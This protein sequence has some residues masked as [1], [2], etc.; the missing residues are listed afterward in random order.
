MINRLA[1]LLIPALLV[2]AGSYTPTT[3]GQGA[4]I[5][6][7]GDIIGTVDGIS[8]APNSESPSAPPMHLTVT[9]PSF[10][11]TVDRALRGQ[12]NF[13]NSCSRRLYWL[14]KT[15][16]LQYGS[17]LSLSSVARYEQRLCSSFNSFFSRI[18][19]PVTATKAVHWR[20]FVK[21]SPLANLHV[22]IEI[23]TVADIQSD[24]ETAF[25]LRASEDI[26]LPLPTSCGPCEC[27]DII[28]TLSP[29]VTTNHFSDGGNAAVLLTIAFSTAR[30]ARVLACLR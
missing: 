14:G 7:H 17:S 30:D 3:A 23:T 20:L 27:S 4:A 24:L 26:P 16:I 8:L 21:P 18:I 6:L 11:Q 22:S 13:I 9:F 29:E 12:G 2:A 5:V 15:S 25:S 28:D 10:T 1:L 19:R